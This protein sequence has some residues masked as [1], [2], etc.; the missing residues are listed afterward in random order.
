MIIGL[1]L[2]IIA[3]LSYIFFGVILLIHRFKISVSVIQFID[4]R[5]YGSY[6]RAQVIHLIPSLMGIV[7]FIDFYLEFEQLRI[8]LSLPNAIL[9][10]CILL[11]LPFAMVY[12][13][14]SSD[15][16]LDSSM[17]DTE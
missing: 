9:F 17:L 11:A 10:V 1:S 7:S 12:L 2:G 3:I 13:Y 5:I 14:Y 6:R 15:Q 16:K 8:D 4:S